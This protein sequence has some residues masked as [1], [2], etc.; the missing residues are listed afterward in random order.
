MKITT[1]SSP[2]CPYCTQLKDFLKE[3]KVEFEE[4]DLGQDPERAE[5]LIKKSGQ[6]GIPVT[7]IE[8]DSKEQIIIGFNREELAK[9]LK[10]SMILP[11]SVPDQ[12]V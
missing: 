5:E 2:N 8:K 3:K 4:V 12:P 10:W 6:M 9:A 7:I 1:Y 11:L